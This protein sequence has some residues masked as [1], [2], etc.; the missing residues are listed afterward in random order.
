MGQSRTAVMVGERQR[1]DRRRRPRRSW[2]KCAAT[3]KQRYKER[4]DAK[5]ALEA[6][7]HHRAG[8]AVSGWTP[9]WT[10]RR[11]YQCEYC[12]GGWHLTSREAWPASAP[13]SPTDSGA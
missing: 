13:S 4:K 9:T 3:G 11:E 10:A 1:C 8:A 2:P 5:E 12:G 6:A 7:W